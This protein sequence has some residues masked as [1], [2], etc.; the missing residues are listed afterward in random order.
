MTSSCTNGHGS[1]TE[2][3]HEPPADYRAE[4]SGDAAV[5]GWYRMP[6]ALIRNLEEA[7]IDI[8][9]FGVYSLLTSYAG[10]TNQCYPSLRKMQQALS[11]GCVRLMRALDRLE[12]AGLIERERRTTSQGDADTTLYTLKGAAKTEARVL[13]KPKHRASISEGTRASIIEAPLHV[14]EESME[15]D[16]AKKSTIERHE[17]SS[18]PARARES[19]SPPV[20]RTHQPERSSK[21]PC[22]Q[23]RPSPAAAVLDPRFVAFGEAYLGH[24]L[25]GRQ[26]TDFGALLA[27]NPSFIALPDPAW[28]AAVEDARQWY[29][30]ET[31]HAPVRFGA[32]A[33]AL[34]EQGR[35][36]AEKEALRVKRPAISVA[37]QS[38]RW[39][40]ELREEELR[41][42]ARR[43]LALPAR[44]LNGGM[45]P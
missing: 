27:A 12:A 22:W 13:S 45:T 28:V 20:N 39:E 33:T 4:S 21:A 29:A 16:S 9:A 10:A 31:G 36:A 40:R 8:V 30:R 3:V 5:A 32:L 19:P 23:K 43:L 44:P 14:A 25:N 11:I 35:R 17:L 1:L 34:G 41:K 38:A 26:A 15:E 7:R 6:H 18:P 24:P 2:C 42:E 37:E